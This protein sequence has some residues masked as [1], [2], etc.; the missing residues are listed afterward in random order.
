MRGIL[1]SLLFWL[2]IGKEK[3]GI[4][5]EQVDPRVRILK[6]LIHW[7][8]W[9]KSLWLAENFLETEEEEEKKRKQEKKRTG[10]S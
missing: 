8:D 6:E 10:M 9:R 1:V 7:L 3:K 2:E 4:T 5:D